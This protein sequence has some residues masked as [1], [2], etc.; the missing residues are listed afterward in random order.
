MFD[1]WHL[2]PISKSESLTHKIEG[3]KIQVISSL[4]EKHRKLQSHSSQLI[5]TWYLENISIH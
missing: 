4:Y 2:K 1:V 5:L 3:K